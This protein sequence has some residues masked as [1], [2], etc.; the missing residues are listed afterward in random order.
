MHTCAYTQNP[1]LFRYEKGIALVCSPSITLALLVDSLTPPLTSPDPCWTL[2][3]PHWVPFPVLSHPHSP[4]QAKEA[5]TNISELAQFLVELSHCGNTG[6][7]TADL[8]A[9]SLALALESQF[10]ASI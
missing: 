4:G 5:D 8:S 7:E 1:H 3:L 2:S 9:L 10:P 6:M